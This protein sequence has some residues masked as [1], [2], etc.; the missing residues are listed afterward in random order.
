M[1]QPPCTLGVN[2]PMEDVMKM[3]DELHAQ[4]ITIIL[5]TH[6]FEVAHYAKRIIQLKDG[7]IVSG[8]YGEQ[9]SAS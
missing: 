7:E 9:E 6:S 2:D 8:V 3:F 5:V 4:G 1:S